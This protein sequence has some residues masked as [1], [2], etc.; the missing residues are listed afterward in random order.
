MEAHSRSS[1]TEKIH[2]CV[3]GL[4]NGLTQGIL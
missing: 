2:F 3:M 1:L 4:R